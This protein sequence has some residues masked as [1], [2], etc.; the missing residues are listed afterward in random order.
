MKQFLLSISAL[1]LLATFILHAEQNDTPLP[2]FHTLS[3]SPHYGQM[4]YDINLYHLQ[5]HDFD[6]LFRLSYT[7]DGFRPFAYSGPVGENWS[8]HAGGS[9]TRE[10][11]GL[12]DDMDYYH[13][14]TSYNDKE[15]IKKGF[16]T[17]LRDPSFSKQT[18]MSFFEGDFEKGS[19][20]DTIMTKS[21]SDYTYDMESDI[22]SFSFNGYA[23]QFI[24]GL[25]GKAVIL[26][27]DYVSIDL[28][29]M[30]IQKQELYQNGAADSLPEMRPQESVIRL[31]TL[32]GYIYTFGKNQALA[33]SL[34]LP[35]YKYEYLNRATILEWML[36][37]VTAPNGRQIHFHY[38]PTMHSL[39]PNDYTYHAAVEFTQYSTAD[40]SFDQYFRSDTMDMVQKTWASDYLEY[41]LFKKHC[42]R[43][44][45]QNIM[46]VDSI[47]TSDN[48]FTIRF[49]YNLLRNQVY[50]SDLF[51][52]QVP[53]N[54]KKYER[55][56][57]AKRYFLTR[58]QVFHESTLLSNCEFSYQQLT[59]QN[60]TRQYLKSLELPVGVKY[61]FEYNT[62]NMERMN[63]I[64]HIDSIDMQGYRISAP[65]FGSLQ[66]ITNPLGGVT[67]LHFSKCRYDSIR[68]FKKETNNYLK[69]V[70]RHESNKTMVNAIVIYSITEMDNNNNILYKKCYE[71][72]VFPQKHEPIH[73]FNSVDNNFIDTT[74]GGYSSGILNVN[75][76]IDV[77]IDQVSWTHKGKYAIC[78]YVALLG[79]HIQPVE[80][81]FARE[82][83]SYGNTIRPTY[84][85]LYKYD[86][87]NNHLTIK[88]KNNGSINYKDIL[89]AYA[90]LSQSKRRESVIIT[91]QYDATG[92]HTKNVYRYYPFIIPATELDDMAYSYS[93][94]VANWYA[95]RTKST[96]F[97]IYVSKKHMVEKQTTLYETNGT[98]TINTTYDRDNYGRL[99]HQTINDGDKETFLHYSYPDDLFFDY[100]GRLEDIFTIGYWG[101]TQMSRINTPVEIVHGFTLHGKNY[102]TGGQINLY[103][104]Y[105]QYIEIDGSAI[106]SVNNT[107][108]IPEIPMPYTAPCGTLQLAL[109]APV[110]QSD[111]TPLSIQNGKLRYDSRYETTST[112]TYD[113]RLR[114]TS[115]TPVGQPTTS[116]TWDDKGLNIISETTGSMTTRY[117]HIPY[118]GISSVTSPQG[119]ITYYSYDTLGNVTEV[120][121]YRN[122]KKV[123]LQAFKY[124]YQSQQ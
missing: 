86:N 26:S 114:L 40:S 53:E 12:P 47:T 93:P 33:Y 111:F 95:A 66:K 122:G 2:T 78:P 3:V 92:I 35:Q 43:D 81:S 27:G 124:H 74:F 14:K 73:E 100:D 7:S 123:I 36:T 20:W 103:K 83:I 94:F 63:E 54:S 112:C 37:D 19:K 105:N 120:W 23:G 5:D 25:D 29:D 101:L 64:N 55:Y 118:V 116:Y 44:G 1:L 58:M 70:V 89:D 97:K 18:S 56:W 119:I 62:S 17:I 77:S 67:L 69:S 48:S 28:T 79:T 50:T 71:Y 72:G 4:H 10:I 46:I 85:N 39:S 117:T 59:S 49:R 82:D 87:T 113:S 9:I 96:A 31:T 6:W 65:T 106:Q 115:T 60:T 102:I 61:L 8:L 57:S 16:L 68:I 110:L 38:R 42:I 34:K 90:Y 52:P 91:E 51:C 108:S 104:A 84:S 15:Y 21:P 30:A 109:S 11:I 107:S 88:I 98:H 45:L 80:Y 76:A 22:Y 99:T 13:F 75:Y 41:S 121:Q 32:D 24:I